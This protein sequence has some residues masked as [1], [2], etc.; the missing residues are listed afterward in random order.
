LSIVGSDLQL[1]F[2]RSE[3]D[4]GLGWF[5]T[6]W[7]GFTTRDL[8]LCACHPFDVRRL[9]GI[10]ERGERRGFNSRCLGLCYFLFIIQHLVVQRVGVH[11]NP[12]FPFGIVFESC[13]VAQRLEEFL[14]R[15][16]HVLGP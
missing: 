4:Q 1:T 8:N 15:D 13:S 14:Y 3:L 2:M 5:E 16:Q 11:L 10:E 9:V 7:N 12:L 6:G